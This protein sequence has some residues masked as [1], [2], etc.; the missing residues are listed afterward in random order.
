MDGM[1]VSQSPAAGEPVVYPWA[2]AN[3]EDIWVEAGQQKRRN[4]SEFT[5]FCGKDDAVLAGNL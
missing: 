4:R 1:L 3:A 5:G 2:A